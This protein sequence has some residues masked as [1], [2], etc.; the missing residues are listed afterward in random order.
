MPTVVVLL[1][2]K[3]SG[4]TMLQEEMC[5]HPGVRHVEYSPHTYFETHHWLKAAVLLGRPQPL[6]SGGRTYDGYGSRENARAYLI[7]TLRG[8]MPDYQP[9]A[10]DE[11]LVFEG[12]EMLC[13][14]FA[15]PVFFEKSPQILA[16]WGALSLLLE[17]AERTSVDLKVIGLVRNPLAVQYSALQL[18][19]T[20]AEQRQFGWLETTRNLLA[21]KAMLPEERFRLWRYEDIIAAPATRFAE[22]CDFIG[23][24]PDERVGAGVHAQ[25]LEKWMEDPTY[26]LQLDRSVTQIA[27]RLGYTP[28]ELL[29]PRQPIAVAN[30]SRS[31]RRR[32]RLALNRLR[33]RVVRPVYLR[34]KSK[35]ASK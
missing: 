5:R 20:D 16:H 31:T 10:D 34:I 29:N 3:R 9:P 11:A 28:V 26:T 33:D 7:D 14:R 15:D 2:D 8:N 24:E 1:S 22:I 30:G 23:I 13:R 21:V 32:F 17:W 19:S 12:W 27:G 6:F 4:S 35:A 18:F 25:S